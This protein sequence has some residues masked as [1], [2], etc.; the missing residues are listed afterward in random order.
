MGP[1]WHVSELETTAFVG[2]SAPDVLAWARTLDFKQDVGQRLAISLLATDE[3]L[4]S[5]ARR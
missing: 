4:A 5:S 2:S 1:C 3:G